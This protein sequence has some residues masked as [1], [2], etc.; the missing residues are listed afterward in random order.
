MLKLSL[1][2]LERRLYGAA[3]ILRREGRDAATVCSYRSV[4]I[5]GQPDAAR[6]EQGGWMAVG[7]FGTLAGHRCRQLGLVDVA[8]MDE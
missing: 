1:A 3:D 2:K 8:A 5:H 7:N 6:L 4:V